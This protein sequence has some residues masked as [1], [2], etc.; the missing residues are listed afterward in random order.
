MDVKR[1]VLLTALTL[2]TFG[3][4][5]RSQD[6]QSKVRVLIIDG[7]N[8]HGW[9]QT[10][11]ACRQ[12]LERTGRFVVKT[13][14]TPPRRAKKEAWAAWR[15][16]LR[17]HDVILSNYNGQP[18]PKAVRE[19]LEGYVRDGGGLCVVHAAD[20]AFP[21]W[22][23]WNVMIGVGGWGGRNERS[24]PMIRFKDG[25][26]VLDGRPGRGGSHGRQHPFVVTTRAPDHP[27]MRGLP[28][29]WM[30][31][32]DE[33]YDRLRGPAKRVTVLATAYSDPATRG[34]GEDEPVLMDIR[35]GNGRVFHTTLGHHGRGQKRFVSLA[36]TGFATTLARG[37]EWAA[38]GKVTL[39]VPKDFPSATT[40]RSRDPSASPPPTKSGPAPKLVYEE[41]FGT[42]AAIAGLVFAN[43]AGWRHGTHAGQGVLELTGSKEYRP[44]H[45]SPFNIALI[46][47]RAVGDFVLEAE[48][49]QN[50]R[51]YGH[52]DLCVFFGFRDPAHYYYAHIA[53]KTDPHAHNIMLVDGS[54]RRK[55]SSFTTSG[56]DWGQN[57]WHRLR[58]VRELVSGKIEVYVNDMEK[59]IM[60][61]T[62]R[63]HGVGLVGFGSFDDT[64]LFRNVRLRATGS[65]KRTV[66]FSAH[67]KKK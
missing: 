10:T 47:D 48:L 20:N 49:L 42:S 21:G 16:K 38:T 7:Q 24:G 64:G 15:P 27:I 18:W 60:T 36:C 4:S 23:S 53:T 19:D 8:N 11:Q 52:R 41:S 32:K 61:A 56:H 6:P 44:P 29:Q 63:T 5:V 33:L 59:P 67:R 46:R 30:H 9:V 66:D 54:P 1:R 51:A 35:Y 14:T 26:M 22:S 28:A 39:P 40:V 13:S 50:G 12:I 65:E 25:K 62:D 34:T 31:A 43:P 58:L 37:T 57:R 45:R 55:I 17:D 2:L 3:G